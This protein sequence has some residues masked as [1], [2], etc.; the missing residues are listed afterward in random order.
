MVK[1]KNILYVGGFELPDRNAAAQ[2]VIANAKLFSTLG[3]KVFFIGVYTN[4]SYNPL[5][6]K[7]VIE[8][9]EYHSKPQKYPYSKSDW[10]KFI[11]DLKF[12]RNVVENDLKANVDIIVA[13]NYPAVSLWKLLKY[14]N[15][16]NIK[17]IA[18][19]TE[20]Y[21]P[22]GNLFFKLIK[23][24]DTYLRMNILHKRVDGLITISKYLTEFYKS[25]NNII[26]LPPLIDKNSQKWNKVDYIPNDICNLIYVGSPGNGIKDSL[27]TI[28][29]SLSRIKSRTRDFNLKIIGITK[30]EYFINFGVEIIPKNIIDNVFFEGRKSHRVA[31][32][33][34]KNSD[35]SIFLR[36]NNLVNKAGFPTKFVES[37][38]CGTPVLTNESSN[39]TQFL[40]EG[41]LGYLI[42]SSTDNKLDISLIKAINSDKELLIEIKNKCYLYN[43]F[44]FNSYKNEFNGFINNLFN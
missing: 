5:I 13:Y 17:L 21:Q 29:Q 28:I 41:E 3:Y 4:S 37:I 39:I 40:K 2:R 30:E 43:K 1:D 24:F 25:S 44:H 35:Y 19:V 12:V 11:T 23:G 27:D 26:Q 18:D 10:F 36:K 7:R 15:K 38:S 22:E 8:G 14:C 9:L 33:E 20:W 42:D 16:N 6:K 31:I 34:I 32:E